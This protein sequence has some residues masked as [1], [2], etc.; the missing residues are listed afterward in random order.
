MARPTDEVKNHIVKCRIGDELYSKLTGN[1]SDILRNA[2]ESYV[3]HNNGFVPQENSFV[4]QGNGN[5][6]QNNDYVTQIMKENERL[7]EIL[8]TL[9]TRV[10]P[11]ADKA[12]RNGVYT[13]L[14]IV[15]NR[16][17]KILKDEIREL[18][19]HLDFVLSDTTCRS[20]VE[21]M[22]EMTCGVERFYRSILDKVKDGEM[23]FNENGFDM[24][25][26]DVVEALKNDEIRKRITDLRIGCDEKQES[27]VRAMTRALKIG[28]DKVRAEIW[29]I[30]N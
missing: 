7:K 22:A 13:E 6:T 14:K 26:T 1:V 27:K 3:T 4:S 10:I 12:F 11:E 20:E 21:N 16:Y 30:K 24:T 17:D 2:L 9:G 28:L 8:N 18:K 23:D 29:G 19:A 25:D 5:V 15:P